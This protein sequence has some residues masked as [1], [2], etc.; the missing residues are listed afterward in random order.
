VSKQ[1]LTVPEITPD[2]DFSNMNICD[3][4]EIIK[5]K[6]F[7]IDE[8]FAEMVAKKA[9]QLTA[10]IETLKSSNEK[11]SNQLN[12]PKSDAKSDLDPAELKR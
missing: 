11:L 7:K 12:K 8:A 5:I 10:K 9:S 4:A 2:H 1:Q 3:K 6:G